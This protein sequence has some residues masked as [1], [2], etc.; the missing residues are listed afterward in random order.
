MIKVMITQPYLR[1]NEFLILEN[2]TIV[3]D[4]YLKTA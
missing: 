1:N 4:S 2:I 3:N